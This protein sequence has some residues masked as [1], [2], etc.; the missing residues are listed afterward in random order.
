MIEH[1]INLPLVTVS[2]GLSV[3]GVIKPFY[4]EN[5]VNG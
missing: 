4:F 5:T 2:C 3:L 1:H